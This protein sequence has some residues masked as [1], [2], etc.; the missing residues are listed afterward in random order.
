M[1][2]AAKN[3]LGHDRV[4]LR[5]NVLYLSE[6][7]EPVDDETLALIR[8]EQ[9]RLAEPTAETSPLARWQFF[10][11][12]GPDQLDIEDDIETAIEALTDTTQRAM[13]RALYRHST[14]YNRDIMDVE[15]FA[16]IKAAL[17]D[18]GKLDAGTFDDLWLTA[19][20]WERVTAG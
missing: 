11:L 4:Y 14:T 18:A 1:L 7:E 20:G 16:T 3:V 6:T 12:I 15:P 13:A 5:E 10:M 9:E 8:A 17:I 19:A 2:D